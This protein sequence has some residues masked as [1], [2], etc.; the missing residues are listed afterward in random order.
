M[1]NHYINTYYYSFNLIRLIE[2]LGL[3]WSF[4][5][6]GLIVS[7]GLLFGYAYVLPESEVQEEEMKMNVN[8][9]CNEYSI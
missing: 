7:T 4:L 1:V 6:M 3:F 2:H 9:N 5:I 8:M